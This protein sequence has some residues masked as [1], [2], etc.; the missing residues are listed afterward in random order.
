M[1]FSIY[2]ICTDDG[3][4]V[5]HT[6]DFNYRMGWHYNCKFSNESC[7]RPIIK[8][9]RATPEDRLFVEELGLYDVRDRNEIE[10]IERYWINKTKSELNKLLKDVGSVIYHDD[11]I[12]F[13]KGAEVKRK[14]DENINLNMKDN[15]EALCVTR[16]MKELHL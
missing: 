14:C 6:T 7:R 3:T 10:V 1:Y 4:Y 13:I 15:Y 16:K 11:V 12:D 8:A 2:Q 5:G 9:I